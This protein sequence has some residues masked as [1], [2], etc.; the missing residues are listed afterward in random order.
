M[1]GRRAG[2]FSGL[3][4]DKELPGGRVGSYLL[5]GLDNC[6]SVSQVHSSVTG[7]RVCIE[8]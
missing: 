1:T 5:G 7:A 3:P 4:G 2:L 8:L 6:Y